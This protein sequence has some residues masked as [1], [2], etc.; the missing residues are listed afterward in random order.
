M[1]YEQIEYVSSDLPGMPQVLVVNADGRARYSSHSNASDPERPEIGRYEA[2]L[3]AAQIEALFATF[4]AANPKTLVDHWGE[5]HSGEDH[6]R[7]RIT[8]TEGVIEKLVALRLPVS[9][10]MQTLIDALDRV[11][12]L[13][14]SSP[15]K[16]LQLDLGPS[17]VDAGGRFTLALSL[18]NS[19]TEPISFNNPVVAETESDGRIE[20]QA[21]PDRDVSALRQDDLLAVAIDG[22]E[23]TE[24]AGQNAAASRTLNLAPGSAV[25][26]RILGAFPFEDPGDYLFRVSYTS[27]A[28][29]ADVQSSIRGRIDSRRVAVRKP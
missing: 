2:R 6:R 19:G 24:T 25:A 12:K 22:I 9:A 13:A 21:W 18:R 11:V 1:T 3:T 16:V 27:Y 17:D 28:D 7:I 15:Q 29:A 4:E 8:T 10:G 14:K 20:I 23:S 26:F 5:V